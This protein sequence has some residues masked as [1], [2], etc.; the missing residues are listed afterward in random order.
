MKLMLMS[1]NIYG[2]VIHKNFIFYST[3]T[4]CHIEVHLTGI[5]T[6]ILWIGIAGSAF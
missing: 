1:T 5:A 6:A 3:Y 4:S 2:H